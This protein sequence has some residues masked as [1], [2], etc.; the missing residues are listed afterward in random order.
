MFNV[1]MNTEISHYGELI[2]IAE[3]EKKI[4]DKEQFQRW[5]NDYKLESISTKLNEKFGSD[6]EDFH[7]SC[8]LNVH[9]YDHREWGLRDD[10]CSD[11]N[12]F[13]ED[14]IEKIPSEII[15]ELIK[16]WENSDNYLRATEDEERLKDNVDNS[17]RFL[18]T[19]Q[20][21]GIYLPT[22]VQNLLKE[23]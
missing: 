14:L 6:I 8:F 5:L 22:I 2:T 23:E 7:W 21:K 20:E 3:L 9:Y 13:L 12:W 11:Q 15:S 1:N 16:I 19:F 17:F 18:K 4:A 10:D